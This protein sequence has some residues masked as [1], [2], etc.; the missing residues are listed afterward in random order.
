MSGRDTRSIVE[1]HLKRSKIDLAGRAF[2]DRSSGQAHISQEFA[3]AVSAEVDLPLETV[4][5]HLHDL[6]ATALIL[7]PTE[8]QLRPKSIYADRDEKIQRRISKTILG[9][10]QESTDIDESE[11]RTTFVGVHFGQLAPDI[12]IDNDLDDDGNFYAKFEED[13]E[14]ERLSHEGLVMFDPDV[15]IYQLSTGVDSSS[16]DVLE[17]PRQSDAV[18]SPRPSDVVELPRQSDAAVELPRQSDAVESPRPSDPLTA[19]D[20]AGVAFSW[21]DIPDEHPDQFDLDDDDEITATHKIQHFQQVD[22]TPK[23]SVHIIDPHPLRTDA[24]LQADQ[25]SLE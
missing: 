8:V 9:V 1:V 5:Q 23:G 18:E 15:E 6:Q 13:I 3:E 12:D 4:M 7:Q 16:S 14:R 17:T 19:S 2:F 24:S 20:I 11:G 21:Q 10:T 22:F 25:S